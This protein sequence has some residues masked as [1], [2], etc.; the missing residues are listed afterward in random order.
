MFKQ[1]RSLLYTIWNLLAS[2]SGPIDSRVSVSIDLQTLLYVF[3]FL[4]VACPVS[5]CSSPLVS[6]QSICYLPSMLSSL[7]LV[8]VPV[9]DVLR[10]QSYLL[11]SFELVNYESSNCC[12]TYDEPH[13]QCSPYM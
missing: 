8:E 1:S 7:R 5:S 13:P 11:R 10:L 3:G 2:G 9:S 12:P 4:W 6:E